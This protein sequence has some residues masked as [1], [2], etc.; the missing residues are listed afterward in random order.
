M[1]VAEGQHRIGFIGAG[2]MATALARGLISSGFTTAA[3]VV[4][5]DVSE[6]ARSQFEAATKASSISSNREAVVGRRVVVLAVKPQQMAGVLADV[7][8]VMTS[9]QLV[10]SIAAGIPLAAMS[11]DPGRRSSAGAGDAQYAVSGRGGSIGV[12]AG[13]SGDG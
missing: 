12:C 13:W 9:D 3:D 8:S 7:A 11:D 4:A 1:T 6:A 10:V 2:R 5:S